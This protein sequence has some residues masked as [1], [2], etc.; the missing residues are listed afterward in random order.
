MAWLYVPGLEDSSSE[1]ELRPEDVT[2]LW[3]TLSGKPTQRPLSWRAWKTRPWIARLSGTILRP[4]MA[5]HGA[6]SWIVS[7]WASRASPTASSGRSAA[8]LMSAPCGL[9]SSASSP[10]PNLELFSART[11]APFSSTSGP[12]GSDY[13]RWATCSHQLSFTPPRKS[14]D[15]TAD[16]VSFSLLPTPI[17]RDW[18]DTPGMSIARGTR[19]RGRLDQ[20]PRV[21]AQLPT[22]T[23]S[24]AKASG[25]AGYSTASG[26]HCGTTL[27]DAVLGAA[28]AGRTGKLNPRLSEWIMGFPKGWISSTPLETQSL[29]T[30][31]HRRGLT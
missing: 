2:G 11:S 9:S 29:R 6:V 26:R 22:P 28:S 17:A 19:A 8:M 30:W 23:A 3:V 27:T 16:P 20:L 10:N 13:E 5:R 14:V 25:A 1:C 24:D 21:I 12:S 18:K 4:S 7:L 31:L 15:L